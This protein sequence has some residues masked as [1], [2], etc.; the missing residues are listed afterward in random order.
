MR[1]TDG[2]FS[3]VVNAMETQVYLT[4]N[5]SRPCECGGKVAVTPSLK[6]THDSTRKHR[7]WLFCKM[8]LEFLEMTTQREKVEHL[9]MM[10]NIVYV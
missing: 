4:N 2:S 9:K 5:Q 3:R 7:E 10:R 6:K 1:K 8:C